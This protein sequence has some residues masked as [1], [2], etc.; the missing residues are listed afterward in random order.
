MLSGRYFH[1]YALGPGTE[2]RHF[3]DIAGDTA[4]DTVISAG[5]LQALDHLVSEARVEYA[6]RHYETYHFLVTTRS[7]YAGGY[8]GIEH[9]QSTNIGIDRLS[10]TDPVHQLASADLFAHEY[11]HSWNGKYRRPV[12]LYRPDFATPV[13]SDLLWVYEGMTQISR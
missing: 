1:E 13:H 9:G 12:Q 6:S 7:D 10:F 8:G 4:A 3:L 5:V 11:T 2:P